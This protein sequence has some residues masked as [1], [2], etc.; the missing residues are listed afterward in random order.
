MTAPGL[1]IAAPF[2]PTLPRKSN[3]NCFADFW[4]VVSDYCRFRSLGTASGPRTQGA[5]LRRRDPGRGPA[6]DGL[7]ADFRRF[8]ATCKSR[9]TFSG[10]RGRRRSGAAASVAAAAGF[11]PPLPLPPPSSFLFLPPFLPPLPSPPLPPPPPASPPPAPSPG[12]GARRAGAARGGAGPKRPSTSW[13]PASRPSPSRS[14]A[15]RRGRGGGGGGERGEG[16][17]RGKGGKRKRKQQ[18]GEER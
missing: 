6:G 4:F 2:F 8:D 17:G 11:L 18:Q 13:P 1:K 3:E 15:S 14:R 16:E 5:K 10:Q 9:I 7:R 12:S